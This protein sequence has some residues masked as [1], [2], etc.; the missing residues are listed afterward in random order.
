[1]T[2]SLLIPLGLALLLLAAVLVAAF[3]L[4]RAV[5]RPRDVAADP[6]P[7]DVLTLPSWHVYT[8]IEVVR[9]DHFGKPTR[10]MEITCRC[11]TQADPES[12]QVQGFSLE[13][14]TGGLVACATRIER[15][16]GICDRC[17]PDR[18]S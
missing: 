1:V 16:E 3:F 11:H 15:V 2:A 8:R 18:A 13:S 5:L 10:A 12:A 7:G 14:W 4:W 9:V 6:R 17:T